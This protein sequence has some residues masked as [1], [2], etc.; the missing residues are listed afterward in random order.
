MESNSILSYSDWVWSQ[1][2]LI[3]YRFCCKIRTR[4]KIFCSP[5]LQRYWKQN[6]YQ[7]SLP[8]SNH[9]GSTVHQ[10]QEAAPVFPGHWCKWKQVAKGL[11]KVKTKY[12]VNFQKVV[13]WIF[14]VKV[15][16]LFL[17][18]YSNFGLELQ[19]IFFFFQNIKLATFP[20]RNSPFKITTRIVEN[21]DLI[22]KIRSFET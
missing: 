16:H 2:F 21:N 7:A 12:A 18:L 17:E 5:A 22:L 4:K 9:P 10:V 3:C 8:K 11:W 20:K 19:C 13:K 6:Q 1:P 15:F 14:M